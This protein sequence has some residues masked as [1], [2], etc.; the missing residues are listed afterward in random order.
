[1]NIVTADLSGE[2]KHEPLDDTGILNAVVP[3][4]PSLVSQF[5]LLERAGFAQLCTP[6]GF[7]VF[8]FLRVHGLDV[9]GL[10]PHRRR[11]IVEQ[12]VAGRAWCFAARRLPT[13]A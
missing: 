8:D 5:H 9:R 2:G 4:Q 13:T 7:M 12:E 10:P 11:Y 6:P 1:L 3:M